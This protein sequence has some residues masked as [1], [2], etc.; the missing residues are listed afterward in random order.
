MSASDAQVDVTP[1][2]FPSLT[3]SHSIARNSLINSLSLAAHAVLGL[4]VAI[5]LAHQL[6][7]ESFGI[8]CTW[9]AVVMLALLLTDA[10]IAT[11]LTA[12]IV[13]RPQTWKQT[14]AQ[15][16]GL[17]AALSFVLAAVLLG[18]GAIWA[19][20]SG[21][22]SIGLQFALVAAACLG[23][24]GQQVAASV[25]RAFERFE[26]ES[27]ARLVQGM[28][29]LGLAIVLVRQGAGALELALAALAISHVLAALLLLGWLHW[30]LGCLGIRFNRHDLRAW[31]AQAIPLTL[32]DWV[33]RLMNQVDTVLLLVLQ[34]SLAAVGI[35]KL[36]CLPLYSL[37]LPAQLFLL[38]LFPSFVRLA[39][40][41]RPAMARALAR[42]TRLLWVV[43]LPAA[44]VVFACAQPITRLLG[45]PD[46]GEAVLPMRI[47]A[48]IVPLN[49][50]SAQ[51]RLILLALGRQRVYVGLVL[52][53]FGI[54]TLL[55]AL[56]TLWGGY[57][58]L[59]IGFL[60]GEVLFVAG[61]WL[62]CR[63]H[64]LGGWDWG[65]M[66]RAAA[67]AT[68]MAGGL[69]LARELPL[70]L[71]GLAALAATGAYGGTC[72]LLGAIEADEKKQLL[73]AFR[74]LMLGRGRPPAC[75]PLDEGSAAMAK[76][77]ERFP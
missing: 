53:G 26:Q 67:V 75:E 15:G 51:Y 40:E 54:E 4:A 62:C 69:W 50:V 63:S 23:V 35:Y 24:Q 61:G 72:L 37:N 73:Q 58:G 5:L 9:L 68:A 20:S 57:V 65:R 70:L 42:S 45:G 25:F 52:W 16:L 17:L 46:F 28:T 30:G 36:A 47:L 32:G 48:W 3:T 8:F 7:K 71:L 64:G 12:R 66:A 59:C 2:P 74:A 55:E 44:V 13:Q 34:G 1:V 10:L 77:S 14:A 22:L 39:G 21:S 38:V 60:L 18:A 33:R 49:F 56:L 27:L 76:G 19:S 6:G 31:L 29:F 11:V 43:S 41:D